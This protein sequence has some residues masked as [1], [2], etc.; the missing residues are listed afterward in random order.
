[1][2]ALEPEGGAQVD[3]ERQ[4]MF[5]TDVGGQAHHHAEYQIGQKDDGDDLNQRKARDPAGTQLEG[6]DDHRHADP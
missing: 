5:G 6:G 2:G 1:M 4:S 3:R